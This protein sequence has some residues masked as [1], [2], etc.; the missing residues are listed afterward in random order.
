LFP[1][2]AKTLDLKLLSM[3]HDFKVNYLCKR[4]FM[5]D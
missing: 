4:E 5:K 3:D 2:I 1:I